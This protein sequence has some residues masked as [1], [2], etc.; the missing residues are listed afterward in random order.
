[1]LVAMTYIPLQE[2]ERKDFMKWG[3]TT[4]HTEKI[5]WMELNDDLMD[6]YGDLYHTG[7]YVRSCEVDT[8]NWCVF[9][10]LPYG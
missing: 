3:K 9:C 6:L 8:V 5:L 10:L 4:L 1:M 7:R 2:L